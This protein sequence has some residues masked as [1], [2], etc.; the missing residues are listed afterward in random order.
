MK[1]IAHKV[2]QGKQDRGIYCAFQNTNKIKTGSQLVIYPFQF[3]KCLKALFFDWVFACPFGNF[4]PQRAFPS[5]E[6]S[7]LN[8]VVS[9]CKSYDSP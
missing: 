5:R 9:Y 2:L 1:Y 8:K 6:S 4:A 3:Q 7:R